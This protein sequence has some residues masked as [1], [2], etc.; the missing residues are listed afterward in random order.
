MTIDV[1]LGIAAI[2]LFTHPAARLDD[3]GLRILWQLAKG[4]AAGAVLLVGC[5]MVFRKRAGV[6]LLHGGVA[7]MMCSELLTG[8]TANEGQMTIDEGAT[9]NYSQDIR[10]TELALIDHSANDQ[11][12]VTVVPESLLVKNVGSADRIEHPNLPF[13]IRVHRWLANSKLRDLVAKENSP[14]TDGA[15]THFAV[16][17]LRQETGIES[18]S[19]PDCAVS[20][21]R[22]ILEG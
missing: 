22:A 14:A 12:R 7:L 10:S 11:D 1:A 5:M 3:S 13:T 4:L 16:D 17:E 9:S 8:L 20:V 21:H 2:W 6:V 19:A 15:G 18:D